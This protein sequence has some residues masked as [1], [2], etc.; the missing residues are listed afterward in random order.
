MLHFSN[1]ELAKNF[2]VSVR[3]VRNW[4][5]AAKEGKLDLILH[6]QGKR[7]YIANTSKNIATIKQLAEKNKKYRPLRSHKIVTPK[8]AFYNLYTEEQIYD[9]VSNIEIHHEIPQQYNYFGE[10]ADRWD[11][12]VE[13]LAQESSP[14]NLNATISLLEANKSYID[15]LLSSYKQVNIIDIAAGNAAPVRNFIEHL[16]STGK[17]GR[18]IAIDISQTMLDIASKNIH[19]WFGGKIT[20][21]QARLDIN[22]DR[23]ANLL[24]DEYTKKESTETANLL[25]LFGG[26]IANFRSRDRALQV[27][28]ESMGIN[29]FLLYEKKLDSESTR[30]YFDFSTTPGD[31]K[32]PAIF[33]LVVDLL[34][35]DQSFFSVDLGYDKKRR[36]RYE[37]IKFNTAVTI[38]FKFNKG[39]RSV[40]LN[41]DDS[42]L[43][44]RAPQ[45]SGFDVLN[46]FDTNDFYP[47]HM[48]QTDNQEYMLAILRL[49]RD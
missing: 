37:R 28:H 46:Q 4:I 7:T 44:W 11:R 12:Y 33:G 42:L 40:Y 5:D 22:Y 39:E 15:F 27:I 21:E 43:V 3:T 30:R 1:Q 8:P 36:E 45:Q 29:D 41:K 6:E 18:Y 24:A 32:L 13:R 48:S 47:L 16:V 19:D 10:G 25:L 14:N 2:H 17:M 20:C 23:F 38:N 34:N 9:L 35:I 49:K 26:T 31:M